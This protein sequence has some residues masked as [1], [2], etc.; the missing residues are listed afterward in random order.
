MDRHIWEYGV[1]SLFSLS[2]TCFA[3]SASPMNIMCA[4]EA[5]VVLNYD[6]ERLLVEL[7]EE[8]NSDC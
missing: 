8:R 1:G 3:V 5:H 2:V 7:A 6:S 4:E